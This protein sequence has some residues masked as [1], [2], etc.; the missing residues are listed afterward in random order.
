[1]NFFESVPLPL[2]ISQ[3]FGTAGIIISLS[4][5]AGKSRA[6]II[7]CKF[8]SDVVWAINYLCLGAYT[9]ALLNVIAMARETV[10]YNRHKRKWA[11]SKIW[12]YVFVA[13]VLISP[14]VD[15]FT[16]DSFSIMPFFPAVGSTFAVISFYNRNTKN[17]R[18][19]GLIA[20]SLWLIYGFKPFNPTGI[21]SCILTIISIAIGFFRETYQK[22]TPST[23]EKKESES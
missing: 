14:A 10:F 9:P 1:M 13:L 11:A 2:L 22:K 18:I 19:F 21:I 4:I 8:V 7:T 16:A 12:L 15:L 5:Y 6:N 17:M 3:I 23:K 20:Q